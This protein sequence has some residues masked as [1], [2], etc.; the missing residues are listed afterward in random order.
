MPQVT[1]T[2]KENTGDKTMTISFSV[3]S[4]I[5]TEYTYA[6]GHVTMN[7]RDS[8][9]YNDYKSFMEG[10]KI[11]RGWINK[12]FVMDKQRLI[13]GE[14]CKLTNYALTTSLNKS[15][16]SVNQYKVAKTKIIK[17]TYDC[18]TKIIKFFPRDEITLHFWDFKNLYL[19]QRGLV[20]YFNLLD[21]IQTINETDLEI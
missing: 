18:K 10:L 2:I 21:E 12:V 16:K 15:G 20:P 14:G 4:N 11:V 5:V 8:T 1:T 17:A 13:K 9:H 19:F 3:D 7:A 6:N